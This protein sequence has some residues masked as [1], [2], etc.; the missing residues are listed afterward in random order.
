MCNRQ[1]GC[2]TI[3]LLHKKMTFTGVILYE[4]E[5][6]SPKALSKFTDPGYSLLNNG[7]IHRS[8]TILTNI[9]GLN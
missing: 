9:T 8:Y 2:G 4:S 1:H 3:I 5:Q 7:N 6:L